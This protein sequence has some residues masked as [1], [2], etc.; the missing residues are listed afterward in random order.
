MAEVYFDNAATT[1]PRPEVLQVMAHAEEDSYFNTAAMYSGSI[2]TR[3]QVEEAA[4][5]ILGR[6]TRNINAG[7]LIFTSGATEGNNIVIFGKIT[8]AR[9]H[10]VV[11]AGEHSSTYA[12]SVALKNAGFPID[13]IP[14]T[15]TG[16]ADIHALKKLIRPTTTLVCFSLVNSDTG[17][18]QPVTEIVKVIRNIAPKAHIHVDAVQGFCKLDFDVADWKVDSVVLSA[19]KLYGPKGIGALWVRKGVTLRPVMYG[20]SQQDYR[21]G[22]EANALIF[23]FAKAVQLFNTRA[24]WE[25]VSALHKRLL[26]GLPKGCQVNGLNNNPYIT[27]I[28]LPGVY[29][30]TVMNALSSRGIFVGMGSA[31]AAKASK[32][33][34]LLAM[35]M[36]EAKTKNVLRISFGIYNTPEEVDRFCRELENTLAFLKT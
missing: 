25:H 21:P 12:P 9:H 34:T 13:Y 4:E 26:S 22:T 29:G 16:E 32:N 27:N 8:Q 3:K 17:T 33:R 28:L 24:S 7:Q 1:R 19:H 23:G 14:L 15:P 2:R 18:I 30:N 11:L 6:L 10:L 5:L 35:G 20:G 36:P 31:C